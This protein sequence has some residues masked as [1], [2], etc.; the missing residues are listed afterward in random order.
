[1]KNVL[2]RTHTGL[3]VVGFLQNMEDDRALSFLAQQR[4]IIVPPLSA[5][6]EKY[7]PPPGLI[8]GFAAFKEAEIRRGVE[9]LATCFN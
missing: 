2:G 8:M 7:F 4:G 5:N 1:M 9:S 3:N 6:A